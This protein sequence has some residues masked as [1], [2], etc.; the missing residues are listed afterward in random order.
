MITALGLVLASSGVALLWSAIAD[1]DLI[2]E[3]RAA[4]A[5]EPSPSESGI[6]PAGS[7][8]EGTPDE[9]IDGVPRGVAPGPGKGDG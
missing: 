5:G 9:A 1:A 4:L 2:A 3:V 6:D 8:H 7:G